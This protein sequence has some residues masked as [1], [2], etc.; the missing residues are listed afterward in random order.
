MTEQDYKKFGALMVQMGEVSVGTE[1]MKR[2]SPQKIKTYFAFLKDLNFEIIQ[3]NANKHF[4]KN[5]WFPAICELRDE[6]D[7]KT[8]TE[9]I[10]AFETISNFLDAYYAPEFGRLTT[11]IIEDKLKALNKTELIPVL[12]KW[13]MEIYS[14]TNITATRAQFIKT[15]QANKEINNRLLEEKKDDFIQIGE[16][17]NGKSNF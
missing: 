11:E 14:R 8:E 13:G 3:N 5:K 10:E 9:A 1:E 7:K 4:C 15:F 6:S 16:F 17:K 12:H 2:P